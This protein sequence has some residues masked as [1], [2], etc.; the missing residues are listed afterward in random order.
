MAA[1]RGP[2]ICQSQSMNIFMENPTF[3]KLNSMHFY[4]WKKGLKT[5]Q[6]YL[7]S[8]AAT[9]AIQF[10]VTKDEENTRRIYAEPQIEA[11]S[12]SIDNP[13]CEACGS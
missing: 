7:R 9:Q 5:G 11:K 6:Y 4:G 1:D 10:T 2:F 12:C 3:N 8:Q 13:D